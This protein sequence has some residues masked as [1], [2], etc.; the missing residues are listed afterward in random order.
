MTDEPTYTL[1]GRDQDS[2]IVLKILAMLRLQ[3]IDLGVRP[4]TDRPQVAEALRCAT[5]ME[6]WHREKATADKVAALEFDDRG[7]PTTGQHAR[8][9]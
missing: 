3:Q 9:K 4:E 2:A 1:H 8:M 5:D 6:I 7:I